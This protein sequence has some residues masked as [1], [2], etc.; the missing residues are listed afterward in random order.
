M[1]ALIHGKGKANQLDF[2]CWSLNQIGY[3]LGSTGQSFVVG[4]GEGKRQRQHQ[5]TLPNC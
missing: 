3:M 4:Y 2:N 1:L 5:H